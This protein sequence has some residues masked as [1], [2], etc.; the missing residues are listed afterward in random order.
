MHKII[1]TFK[2]RMICGDKIQKW[3]LSYPACNRLESWSALSPL[4]VENE[5]IHFPGSPHCVAPSPHIS[6]C[7]PSSQVW[8][9]VV[10]FVRSHI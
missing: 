5:I 10:C 1:W 9:F 2:S 8:S 7:L 4:L 3:S 6:I